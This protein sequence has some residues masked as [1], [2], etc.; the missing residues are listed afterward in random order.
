MK[1]EKKKHR[2]SEKGIETM[3]RI[4]AA[5]HQRLSEMA[6]N[7][8]HIMITV[9]SII[10]S[11]IISV[12]LRR[13]EE[14]THLTIPSVLLLTVNVSALIFAVLATRPSIPKGYTSSEDIR[15]K[16]ANLLFFGNFYKLT[17]DQYI[18]GMFNVMDDSD[19]LYKS[20][21]RDIYSQGVVL[22]IKYKLLRVSYNI[23]MFGIISSVVAFILAA[24][25]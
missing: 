3:F 24:I 12:L 17:Q 19:Y 8:A 25:N 5:N 4:A 23:F 11:V 22:S 15:K 7:K 16:Q 14:Y 20:L 6:D 10:L 13:I 18:T 21:I 9:N 2:G 1:P